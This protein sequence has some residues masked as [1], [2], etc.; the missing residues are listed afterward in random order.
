MAYAT[1]KSSDG[2][3]VRDPTVVKVIETVFNPAGTVDRL[4]F[5]VGLGLI[6][7]VFILIFIISDLPQ[8]LLSNGLGAVR[9]L[10]I[11]PMVWAVLVLTIKR[12]KDACRSP[13]WALALL[14]PGANLLAILLIGTLQKRPTA[15]K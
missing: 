15:H 2:R 13:L 11:A 8:A 3:N 14:I 7:V 9:L 4:Q 10:M 5:W 12:L 6:F 1:S